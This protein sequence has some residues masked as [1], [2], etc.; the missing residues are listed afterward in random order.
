M[1]F[2]VNC[3][4]GGAALVLCGYTCTERQEP[5]VPGRPQQGAFRATLTAQAKHS[6]REGRNRA[7][8]SHSHA[9]PEEIA[10]ANLTS[11]ITNFGEERRKSARARILES[12]RRRLDEFRDLLLERLEDSEGDLLLPTIEIVRELGLWEAVL[13]LTGLAQFAAPTV[14]AAA[15][16]AVEA[17]DTWSEDDLKRLLRED[18]PLVLVAT[19]EVCAGADGRP[20]RAHH[21]VVGSRRFSGEG[22][23]RSRH[24]TAQS[25]R[26]ARG[27]VCFGPA[28]VGFGGGV[29]CAGPGSPRAPGAR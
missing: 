19:L 6:G 4:L 10:A 16:A 27:A 13:P 5:D 12:I 9:S 25:R 11:M 17:L 3:L 29:V 24:S 1:L 15:I 23:G 26:A 2:A 20:A 14:R 21:R 8:M 7:A 28:V 22:R 18:Q